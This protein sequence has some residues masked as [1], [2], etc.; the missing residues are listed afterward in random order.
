MRYH[1]QGFRLET[2]QNFYVGSGSRT[3]ELY[4]VSPNRLGYGFI[5][6]KVV[7]C[8]EVLLTSEQPVHFAESDTYLFPFRK[9][10]F[11]PGKS[12]VKM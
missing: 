4:P 6:Y 7:A 2:F 11:M 10:V 12:S 8:C 1:A 5:D 3:P 9:D